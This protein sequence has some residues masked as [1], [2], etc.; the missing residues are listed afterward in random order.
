MLMSERVEYG[1]FEAAL[2]RSRVLEKK[3]EANPEQ[4]KILTGD[5]PTGNLHIGHYFG[6]LENRVR[7]AESGLETFVVI[8]DYQV[9]TDRDGVGPIKERVYSL[10]ADY[11]AAGLDPE[12]VTI[13]T[14]SSVPALN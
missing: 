3:L 7:L 1:T 2:E 6:S 12:K 4:Y 5:R 13:F 8:A 14:H 11:L 9:I 10:L